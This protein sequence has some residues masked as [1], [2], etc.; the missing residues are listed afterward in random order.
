MFNKINALLQVRSASLTASMHSKI[1]RF[2]K[3][4]VRCK[5]EPFPDNVMLDP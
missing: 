1:L 3:F 5:V 2:G 4:P